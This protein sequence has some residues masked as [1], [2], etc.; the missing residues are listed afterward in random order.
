LALS[1]EQMDLRD[2]AKS[3]GAVGMLDKK[4]EFDSEARSK[5]QELLEISFKITAATE[6]VTSCELESKSLESQVHKLRSEVGGITLRI[7]GMILDA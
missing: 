2:E 7:D 3:A 5:N 4:R 1:D 6:A